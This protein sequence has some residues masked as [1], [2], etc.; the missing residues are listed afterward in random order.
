MHDKMNNSS[1][2]SNTTCDNIDWVVSTRNAWLCRQE[3]VYH[4]CCADEAN[5][6]H[7]GCVDEADLDG[8]DCADEAG[9]CCANE[10]DVDGVVFFYEAGLMAWVVPTRQA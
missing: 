8:L 10:V 5:L 4:L 2:H 9:L 6:S 7:L 1:R 3:G